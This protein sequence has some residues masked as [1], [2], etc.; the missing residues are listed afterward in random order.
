MTMGREVPV[1]RRN[2]L[3]DRR[4]VAVSLLGV[5]LAVALMLLIQGLW[6]G[7]LA[8]ITAYEDNAGAQLFVAER[9]TRSFQ[10]DVSAVQPS[11]VELIREVPGV[12]A[13][14]PIA[15]RGLILELH[16]TKMPLTLI[17][18]RIGGLGGPWALEDGRAAAADDEIVIDAGLAAD[19]GY[20]IG[21]RFEVLG[22]GLEIVGLTPD[23]RAL[24]NGGYLFVSQATAGRLLGATDAT[25]FVLVRTADPA[26]AA[27]RIES[28]TDLE[29]L[30][31]Q[32]IA[33]GDRE[34]YDDTLGSVIRVMLAIAFTAGTLIVALSVYSAVVDRIR[35]YGI[36]KALGASR[37]RLL[38][39]VLAQT[40][41]LALAGGVTGLGLFTATKAAVA[42][43]LPEFYLEL[44]GS[45]LL[46][47]SVALAAMALVA[48]VLPVRRIGRL[49]PAS[50]YRG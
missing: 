41:A 38:G 12:E 24:G 37:G 4:R 39:I 42:A 40:S 5:G 43:W 1:G 28:Q 18:A 3:S 20:R 22:V 19:H 25:S 44:P 8:R 35:E 30:T 17:G 50:V 11:A 9:G 31:A 2:L 49:D 10:S 14:E 7:T 6:S 13:A 23:T 46:A 15:A 29:V 16:S 26:G 21:E 34:V 27:G 36:L 32:E 33:R 45:I 48:A 47:A